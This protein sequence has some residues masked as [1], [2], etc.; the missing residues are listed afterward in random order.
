MQSHYG[1]CP[2][3]FDEASPYNIWNL[4]SFSRAFLTPAGQSP[5]RAC[6]TH[7]E[8]DFREEFV[9]AD[10]ILRGTRSGVTVRHGVG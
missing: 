9:F 5:C 4:L 6:V 1:S 8:A 10:I 3:A 7:V 2:A